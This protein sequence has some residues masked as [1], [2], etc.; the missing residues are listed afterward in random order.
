MMFDF[1][2]FVESCNYIERE[3]NGVVLY[4]SKSSF[5]YRRRIW[6]CKVLF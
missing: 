3:G 1:K 2:K 4:F 5:D 6:F